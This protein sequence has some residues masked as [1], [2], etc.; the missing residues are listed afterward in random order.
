MHLN[1]SYV[2]SMSVFAGDE[3]ND[4]PPILEKIPHMYKQSSSNSLF[5]NHG[6]A[7]SCD[8]ETT[9]YESFLASQ[10]GHERQRSDTA[11]RSY[12]SSK[13]PSFASEH[14]SSQFGHNSSS[15]VSRSSEEMNL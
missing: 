1:E 7:F 11:Y 13:N 3:N 4:S 14:S 6:Y 15:N 9:M 5:S 2:Q 8:E 10:G 12:L